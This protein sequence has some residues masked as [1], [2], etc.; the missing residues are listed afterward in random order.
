MYAFVDGTVIERAM[1]WKIDA[2][3][4]CHYPT[5]WGRDRGSFIASINEL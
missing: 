1:G 5:N 3:L 4:Y 2:T